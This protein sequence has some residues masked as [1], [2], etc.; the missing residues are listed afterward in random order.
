MQK[1]KRSYWLVFLK[2][3]MKTRCLQVLDAFRN[4]PALVFSARWLQQCTNTSSPLDPRAIKHQDPLSDREQDR[5]SLLP[6]D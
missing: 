5:T 1:K 3:V 6:R 2:S 4:A